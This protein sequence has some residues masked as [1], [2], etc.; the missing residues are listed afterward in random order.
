MASEH[1]NPN[2]F[3]GLVPLFPNNIYKP[4]ISQARDQLVERVNGFL[5]ELASRGGLSPGVRLEGDGMIAPLELTFFKPA[6]WQGEPG[7]RLIKLRGADPLEQQ[8][9]G[10]EYTPARRRETVAGFSEMALKESTRSQESFII[11]GDGNFRHGM[12]GEE[13]L[14]VNNKAVVDVELAYSAQE[15]LEHLI[16]LIET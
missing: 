5:G 14:R 4:E 6:N 8:V 10:E 2:F 16:N 7:M 15:Q 9:Y 12:Q 13:D 1:D 11:F 3:H